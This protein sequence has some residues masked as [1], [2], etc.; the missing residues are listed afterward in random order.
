MFQA[1]PNMFDFHVTKYL[2]IMDGLALRDQ[3]TPAERAAAAEPGRRER[4]VQHGLAGTAAGV[5]ALVV[6]AGVLGAR[7]GGP[8]L[9]VRCVGLALLSST[10]FLGN[11]VVA[12]DDTE[13]LEHGIRVSHAFGYAL[14]G[15][16]LLPGI[17]L[18]VTRLRRGAGSGRLTRAW[19]WGS[20]AALALLLSEAAQ[21]LAP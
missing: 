9:A 21:R 12:F 8:G 1:T 15:A 3:P 20:L 19:L 2:A 13:Q 17:F 11:F 10:L 18:G 6:V 16:C 14:A 5:L 4:R 7:R